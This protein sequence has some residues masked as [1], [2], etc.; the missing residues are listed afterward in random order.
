MYVWVCVCL[1]VSLYVSM[2]VCVCVCVYHMYLCMSVWVCVYLN[3]FLSVLQSGEMGTHLIR[4]QRKAPWE[5]RAL[6]ITLEA[7]Q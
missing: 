6:D 1:Y 5:A 4:C 3:D 7:K 2:Y